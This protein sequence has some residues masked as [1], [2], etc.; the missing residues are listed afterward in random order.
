VLAKESKTNLTNV[1]SALAVHRPLYLN[2]HI[3][4]NAPT[5]L[6]CVETQASKITFTV[7]HVDNHGTII[8]QSYMCEYNKKVK[9]E[10]HPMTC[11]DST[12]G[13]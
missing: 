5:A 12:E 3:Q 13:E 1:R 2:S 7:V 10:V 11:H 6:H 8:V 9:P 4:D